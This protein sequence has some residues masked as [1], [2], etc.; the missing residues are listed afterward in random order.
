MVRCTTDAAKYAANCSELRI[1]PLR[2]SVGDSSLG[3]RR[4]TTKKLV[5]YMAGE[6]SESRDLPATRDPGVKQ[7][8]R[9][10]RKVSLLRGE[11]R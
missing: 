10:D 3:G 2:R 1:S 7:R 11:P 9:C 4:K 6:L 8:Q 5:I